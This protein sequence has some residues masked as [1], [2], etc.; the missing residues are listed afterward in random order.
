MLGCVV[1]AHHGDDISRAVYDGDGDEAETVGAAFRQGRTSSLHCCVGT[2]SILSDNRRITGRGRLLRGSNRRRARCVRHRCVGGRACGA[3]KDC[4]NRNGD[5]E[6]TGK[7][8]VNAVVH[9]GHTFNRMVRNRPLQRRV[10]GRVRTSG[11]R[12]TN[13]APYG[14]PDIIR[15]VDTTAWCP[16]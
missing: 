2:E 16:P 15:M 11:A 13:R 10:R 1:A 14:Y 8:C 4:D 9:V 12:V 5:S 7:S 6:R 3:G